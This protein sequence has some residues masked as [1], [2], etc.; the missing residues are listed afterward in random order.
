MNVKSFKITPSMLEEVF[1]KVV[2]ERSD[3]TLLDSSL[4][5][6]NSFIFQDLE[7]GST[8]L[9]S[10]PPTTLSKRDRPIDFYTE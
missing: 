8:Q 5:L 4:F 2:A 7:H 1:I 6:K 10:K 3:E 9:D